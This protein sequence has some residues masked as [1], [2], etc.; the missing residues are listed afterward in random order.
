[1]IVKE[2]AACGG[3]F[4]AKSNQAKYCSGRCRQRAYEAKKLPQIPVRSEQPAVIGLVPPPAQSDSGF[5]AETREELEAAGRTGTYLARSAL[6]LARVV[7]AAGGDTAA[8][9]SALIREYK[10]TMASALEGVDKVE[11]PVDNLQGRRDRRR[12]A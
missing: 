12:S 3:R 2:C 6:F 7:D 9:Y 1:M 10:A 11:D 8:G 5:E 4:Q